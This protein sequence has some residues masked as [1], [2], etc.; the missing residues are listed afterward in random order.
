MCFIQLV[1]LRTMKN[2][3]PF[4]LASQICTIVGIGKLEIKRLEVLQRLCI[5]KNIHEIWFKRQFQ[6][7]KLSSLDIYE[8]QKLKLWTK[9]K[10]LLKFLT[11]T[12]KKFSH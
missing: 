6:K 8:S 1:S 9:I 10:Y 2:I 11:Q 7:Q 5:P 12:V 4:T 3:V